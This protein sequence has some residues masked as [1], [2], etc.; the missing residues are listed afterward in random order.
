MSGRAETVPPAVRDLAARLFDL[1]GDRIERT[2]TGVATQM[3]RLRFNTHVLYMRVA[4]A[5]ADDLA[6][7][8]E[9]HRRMRSLGAQAPEVVHTGYDPELGRSVLVMT[10]IPGV[11]LATVRDERVALEVAEAAGADAALFGEIPVQGFGWLDRR[12]PGTPLGAVFDTYSA[13]VTSYM[14]KDASGRRRLVGPLLSAQHHDAIERMIDD[15]HSRP[16]QIG[17]LV[18]GDLDVTAVYCRE[19]RYSGIIDFSELRGAEPE[20]DPGHFLLHDRE[21][22]PNALFDAFMRGWLRVRPEV[23]DFDRIRRSAILS[24]YRQLCRW[25]GPVRRLASD[26][27]LPRLRAAELS[28]LLDGKP[29]APRP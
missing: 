6:A 22:N 18:H 16:L 4:E 28:N 15:E 19:G 9:V 8:A 3:Y 12:Q 27:P 5:P 21:T 25:L 7:D 10:E 29:A 2:E 23:G 17:R 1:P 11:S 20:F 14:P 13:F 24:G 26:H